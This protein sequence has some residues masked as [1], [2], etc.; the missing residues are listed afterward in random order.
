MRDTGD[1]PPSVNETPPGFLF[2]AFGF[3]GIQ[4]TGGSPYDTATT[5]CPGSASDRVCIG[6]LNG[7]VVDVDGGYLSGEHRFDGVG[8][9]TV[10]GGYRRVKSSL[11]SDY[12]GENAFL[13]VSIRDDVREQYSLEARFSSDFSDRFKFTVGGMYWGQTMNANATSYLGFLRFLGDPTAT[14]DPNL[15]RSEYK[16]DSYAVFGEAEYQVA[17]PLHIFFGA[18]YTTETKEF[19]RQP[20]V[21]RSTVEAGFWPQFNE[22]A[23]FSK[24]TIRAGYRWEVTDGIN[25]YFTYSQG[26]KSGGYNEEAMSATSALPFAE[27]TADSFELGLKTETA[28]RRLRF[29]AAA[30]YVKY[31][32][33]QRDAVV[34]FIDPITM[35]P[36]QETRTTNA[37]KAEVY[38][39]ELEFGAVPVDG[40]TLGAAFGYQKAK[41][42]AFST[43]IDGSGVNVDASFL[44][45]RNTPEITAN[46]AVGYEFPPQPW[47]QVSANA[48]LNY[49]SE[50]ESVTLNASGTQGQARTLIGASLIWASPRDNF[51]VS[52]FGRNLLDRVYRVSGN[53]VA[54]LWNFTNYAPPRTF[55]VE[56]QARF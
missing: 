33:L 14:S 48:D 9:L 28:D 52:V 40:L 47:G 31:N 22:K 1:T 45:F 27:E 25:N 11:P 50:F 17:D 51:Q 10:V 37:G 29:N 26:Y 46:F 8:A 24:P 19:E 35:L 18:R 42:L 36:G 32:D 54:G 39:L 55:G 5:L 16:V 15:S 38:G 23:T 12:T 49:Q 44:K 6:T 34:P 3:P 13:F 56:L 7:H 30:F 41:Y 21:R 20:Q 53:S 4:T 2:D 43:D